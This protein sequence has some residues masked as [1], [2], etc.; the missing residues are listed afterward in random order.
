MEEPTVV[1]HTVGYS[2]YRDG[3]TA[4][5]VVVSALSGYFFLLFLCAENEEVK[6]FE[7]ACGVKNEQ[8]SK[9]RH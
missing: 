7:D 3:S 9:P 4:I 2:D 8:H 6:N 5:A 1:A